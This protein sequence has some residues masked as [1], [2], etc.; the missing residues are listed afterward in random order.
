[1]LP[2]GAAIRSK[3]GMPVRRDRSSPACSSTP[4]LQT[5]V[6]GHGPCSANRPAILYVS[7]LVPAERP[8][9]PHRANR[10]LQ[11]GVHDTL[12]GEALRF[13]QNRDR[14]GAAPL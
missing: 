14:E 1:M 2:P 8:P 6:A 3:A 11:Q 9:F 4:N 7:T 13:F 12:G 5:P 10:D